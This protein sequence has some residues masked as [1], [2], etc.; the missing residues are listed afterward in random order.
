VEGSALRNPGNHHGETCPR[1]AQPALTP[2][3][4]A[5]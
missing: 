5:A 2:S 3:G 4:Q 1:R